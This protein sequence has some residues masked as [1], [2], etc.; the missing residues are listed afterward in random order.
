MIQPNCVRLK[1]PVRTSKS[2]MARDFVAGRGGAKIEMNE[3]GVLA[4]TAGGGQ[5]VTLMH[6]TDPR[7]TDIVYD[8]D[9]AHAEAIEI[10]QRYTPAPLA[11][12]AAPAPAGEPTIAYDEQPG[13]GRGRRAKKVTG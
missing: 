1:V 7:I 4:L 10:N 5:R 3:H 6:I 2:T 8:I 13:K 9:V 12:E 11:A